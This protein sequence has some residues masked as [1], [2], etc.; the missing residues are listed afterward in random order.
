MA[1][2]TDPKAYCRNREMRT[3]KPANRQTGIQTSMQ[4]DRQ[5]GR[6]ADRQTDGQ[7]DRQTDKQTDRQTDKQ[8][9]MRLSDDRFLQISGVNVRRVRIWRFSKTNGGEITKYTP[10]PINRT[11]QTISRG[12]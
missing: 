8:K 3:Q 1:S 9:H 5:E 4:R 7:T 10:Y 6:Q 11:P 2:K 12:L